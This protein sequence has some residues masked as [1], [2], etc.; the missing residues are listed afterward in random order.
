MMSVFCS[1]DTEI[2]SCA[3]TKKTL[4]C[5]KV[6]MS[7]LLFAV[8]GRRL[9]EIYRFRFSLQTLGSAISAWTRFK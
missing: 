7:F 1:V 3:D 4:L 9:Q 6:E 2:I 5:Q 8:R